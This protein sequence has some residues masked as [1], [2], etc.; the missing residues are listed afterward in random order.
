MVTTTILVQM[1]F[2]KKNSESTILKENLR[3]EYDSKRIKDLLMVEQ[4]NFCAYSERYL[5]PLDAVE[6]EH[7]NPNQKNTPHDSYFNWY[8]TLRWMNNH[9]YKKLNSRFLPIC[10]PYSENLKQRIT[11]ENGVFLATDDKDF[12]IIN[13]IEFLGLNKPEVYLERSNHV[14]LI[15]DLQKLAGNN[16]TFRLMLT[17]HK[18]YLSFG[19]ALLYELS[20]DIFHYL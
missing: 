2:L 13:L 20:I 19:T 1:L 6:V 8:A 7:F 18:E 15:K 9:K 4:M 11:Y 14:K 16:E 10:L 17:A 3:Y 12:E 5:K